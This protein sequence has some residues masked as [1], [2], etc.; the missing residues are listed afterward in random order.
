[1]VASSFAVKEIV[2]RGVPPGSSRPKATQGVSS[3]GSTA[4]SG[5]IDAA[6][7][8]SRSRLRSSGSAAATRK[9]SSVVVVVA[10]SV[11][12]KSAAAGAS[13]P[14]VGNAAVSLGDGRVASVVEYPSIAP[15][16]GAAAASSPVD[17]RL[18]SG[19]AATSATRDSAATVRAAMVSGSYLRIGFSD[20]RVGGPRKVPERCGEQASAPEHPG[21]HG[22]DRDVEDLRDRL[23]SEALDV[24]EHH[25]GTELPGEGRQRSFQVGP[26]LYRD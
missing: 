1:M 21:L 17:N 6:S 3:S 19:T 24:G 18:A 9:V 10:A 20:M 12:A 4:R 15:K 8:A 26:Q 13:S 14:S 11:P 2:Y 16:G 7:N 25:G 5:G 22:A 23:Q